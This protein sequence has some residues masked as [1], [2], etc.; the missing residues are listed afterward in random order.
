MKPGDKVLVDATILDMH[1]DDPHNPSLTVSINGQRVVTAVMNCHPEERPDRN[2]VGGARGGDPDTSKKAAFDIYPR[3]GS[4]R[5]RALLAVARA[6]A[7][8]ATYDEVAD[9]TGI[10]GVWKRLSELKQG[11]WLTTSGH[12]KVGS[13]GSDADVYVLTPKAESW[14]LRKETADTI[15]G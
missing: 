15:S 6:G 3:S 1:D 2:A 10:E 14:L 4:Y 12:R 13:T 11:G 8:G 9:A 5:H 7:R